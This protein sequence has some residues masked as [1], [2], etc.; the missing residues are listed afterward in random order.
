VAADEHRVQDFDHSHQDKA[1][2]LINPERDV[3][4]SSRTSTHATQQQHGLSGPLQEKSQ[5]TFSDAGADL[6][7]R[8]KHLKNPKSF[9]SFLQKRRPD[10]F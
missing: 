2:R 4:L 5:K 8:H 10:F 6:Q 7:R 9:A 3:H 1:P